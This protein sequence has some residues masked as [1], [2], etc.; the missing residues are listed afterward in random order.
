MNATSEFKAQLKVF[1]MV[2]ALFLYIHILA[3]TWW[4][5]VVKNKTWV[6]ASDFI[7]GESKLFKEGFLKSYMSML[8]HAMMLFGVNEVGPVETIELVVAISLMTLSAIGNAYI[9]GEMAMLVQ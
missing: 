5:V 2:F 6:P 7:Y 8:Y 3:C 9:F 4:Y 1:Q